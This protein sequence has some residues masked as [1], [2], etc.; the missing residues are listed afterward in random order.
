MAGA[1]A[2][3]V[4]LVGCGRLGS[5]MV[6]GWL[7][8]R[9]VDPAGLIIIT[10]SEKPAAQR[11]RAAGARINPPLDEVA[12]ASTVVLAVKPGVWRAA[13]A[14][15]S[16]VA[17]DATILSV[18]AGVRA[19]AIGSVFAANPIARVMPTTGVAQARGVASIWSDDAGARA[20]AHALFD[21]VAETIDL[22]EEAMMDAATAMSG[23]GPA[24]VHALTQALAQAGVRAGLPGVEAERLARATLAS[25]VAEQAGGE[26]LDALIARVAS[27]GGT[28]EAGLAVL[29][30]DEALERL[31]TATVA[32]AVRRAGELGAAAQRET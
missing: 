16:R 21:P 29:R 6:E 1:A 5:A 3:S 10:P 25:A 13:T 26:P 15:L 30:A 18:M 24:Y 14:G 28:T 20:V 31:M 11:A 32:A 2:G 4:V 7:A 12:G 22:P 8:T 23:S 19:A 9:A 27:P 17:E